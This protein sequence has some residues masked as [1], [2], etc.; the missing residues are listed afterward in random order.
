MADNPYVSPDLTNYNA[1]PPSD[2]GSQTASNE[3]TWSKH[4]DKLTDP[5][6]TYSEA[7]DTATSDAFAK[8]INTDA[9]Q[10]NAVAGSLAFTSSELTIA[11]GSVAAVRSHHTIDTE[12]DAATDDLDT[13]DISSVN[14]GAILILRL[15][16]AARVVTLKHG[17]GNINLKG[18]VDIVLDANFP[19]CL[20]R[21]GANWFQ[22]D[23]PFDQSLNTDDD[24][25]F[26]DIAATS[27]NFGDD[28]VTK[29]KVTTFAPILIFTGG[30]GTIAY[31]ARSGLS[32][33]D[34]DSVKV[35]I[36]LN[37]TSIA[38]RTGNVAVGG[39]PVAAN[40]THHGAAICGDGILLNIAAGENLTGITQ[41][42]GNQIDLKTWDNT[43]GVS[44]LDSPEWSDDGGVVLTCT[45][46]K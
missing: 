20:L 41:L 9:N 4:K 7:Q 21:V 2:D 11:T 17:T 13:I 44:P 6:K 46:P 12:A 1:N 27:I 38:S 28:D 15:E 39:L 37:S 31:G 25:Q 10:A 16:D 36:T 33:E 18:G 24:V 34:T 40:A 30:S 45:Y 19:I 14:D 35:F 42:G 22:E 3:V 32:I 8:T 23:N 43:Q 29:Y 5:L 26:N